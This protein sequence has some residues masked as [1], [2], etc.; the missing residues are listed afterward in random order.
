M[1]RRLDACEDQRATSSARNAAAQRPSSKTFYV[2]WTTFGFPTP[3]LVDENPRYQAVDVEVDERCV[4]WSA[5]DNPNQA[6]RISHNAE[7]EC[8]R[9]TFA[10]WLAV[11]ER[12]G[13]RLRQR[14][15]T[16][17]TRR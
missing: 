2:A 3:I 6:N 4:Y 15:K 11:I 10:T 16:T 7:V 17:L 8:V 13:D 1:T 14:G 5:S 9:S 12:E